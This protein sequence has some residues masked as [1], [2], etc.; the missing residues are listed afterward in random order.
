MLCLTN[1]FLKKGIILTSIANYWFKKTE[2][3][4]QNHLT[5]ISLEEV[6]SKDEA[7][8]LHWSS[9]CR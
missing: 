4:V 3:I 9:N 8:I 1:P 2:H 5:D 7:E 6:L